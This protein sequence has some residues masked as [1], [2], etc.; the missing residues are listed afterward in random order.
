MRPTSTESGSEIDSIETEPGSMKVLPLGEPQ[1]VT[2]RPTNG[3]SYVPDAPRYGPVVPNTTN[4]MVRGAAPNASHATQA[5]YQTAQPV[6]Q[7]GSMGT[8]RPV[9][10]TIDQVRNGEAPIGRPAQSTRP[11]VPQTKPVEPTI[12][13]APARTYMRAPQ[14]GTFGEPTR[15]IVKIST[16]PSRR[17]TSESSAPAESQTTGRRDSHR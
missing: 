16:G 9:L 5:S 7:S 3:P 15:P 6:S 4:A 11:I 12:A 13:A 17:Q 14:P 10:P 1:R 8:M 2:P